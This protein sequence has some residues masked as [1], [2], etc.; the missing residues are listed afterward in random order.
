M[1]QRNKPRLRNTKRN[2]SKKKLIKIGPE[3]F[4]ISAAI[5]KTF[6]PYIIV[7]L[8]YF[9][10][11]V[12]LMTYSTTVCTKS[13]WIEAINATKIEKDLFAFKLLYSLHFYVIKL[14]DH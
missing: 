3:V 6:L 13:S 14:L 8:L 12:P 7:K 9:I 5:R 2:I 4:E 10:H 1:Q 11:V